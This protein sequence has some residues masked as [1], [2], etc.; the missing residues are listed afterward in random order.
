MGPGEI[1]LTS[2]LATLLLGHPRTSSPNLQ[3]IERF[4][5]RG[6]KSF[7]RAAGSAEA[8]QSPVTAAI[9]RLAIHQTGDGGAKLRL[10]GTIGSHGTGDSLHPYR[11]LP[12][13]MSDW[14]DAHGSMPVAPPAHTQ[15]VHWIQDATGLSEGR[16]AG[17]LGVERITVRNWK[18]GKPIKEASLRRLFETKDVLQRARRQ[19]SRQAE[20]VAWLHTPDLEHGI[21]PATLLSQG[22][23]DRARFL[24]ILAPTAVESLPAW[25]RR[26]VAAAWHGAL[27]DLERPGEFVVDSS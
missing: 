22:E 2:A 14:T 12:Q 25:A 18:A 16:V 10:R 5:D 26:P 24:A 3:P 27:E 17:L 11:W 19:Y 20:L 8:A 1:F 15:A 21:S 23:F 13:H 4:S 9:D 7:D 6:V